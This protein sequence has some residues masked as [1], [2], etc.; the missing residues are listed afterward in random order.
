MT[1]NNTND[2]KVFKN[3]A[4]ITIPR[5]LKDFLG[6]RFILIDK[7][8]GKGKKPKQ[9][10]WTT[11]KNYNFNEPIL[12]GHIRGG[13][14]YG[15]AT[16]FGWLQCFDADQC[17]RLEELGILQKLPRT[18][19][20]KTGRQSS[21]GRHYWY[22]IEGMQ[23]RLIFHDKELK[24]PEKED[25]FL[26][27][28]SVQSKGNYAIG[29]NCIHYSGNR[30]EIIDDS[31]IATL[32]YDDLLEILKPT[33]LKKKDDRPKDIRYERNGCNQHSHQEV[34]IER[35]GWPKGNVENANGG[36]EFIGTHPFHDSKFGRN[37][38]INPSKGVWHCFRHDSGGGWV[39][40]L[41][42]KEGIISC[43]QAGKGCL[44]KKQYREVFQKAEEMGLIEEK[45]I[46]APIKEVLMNRKELVAIPRRAPEGEMVV[47]R[48][49]PR[50][51]KSHS[52]CQWLA[53]AGS[54]NYIT[55]NHAIV[56]HEIKIAKELRM[57]GVV[58]IIGMNQPGACVHSGERKCGECALKHGKDN[59]FELISAAIKL[60]KEKEVLT[61][62]DIPKNYCPYYILKIA[63]KHANYCFTVV[64]NINNIIPRKLTIIDEEPT[65]NHFYATSLEVATIK[66]RAGESASKNFL[67]KSAQIQKELDQILN[68]RKKPALKEYAQKIQDISKIIDNGI[69]EGLSVGDIADEIEDSLIQFAPKHREVRDEGEHEEG[70]DLGI[71]TCVRCIGNLYKENPINV[72]SKPGGYQS[73]Y[74]LGDER[75]PAFAMDWLQKTEKIIIIGATKAELFANEFGGREIIIPDFIY[76]DRFTLIG[77]EK[78]KIGDNRGARNAQKKKVMDIAKA[79]WR[80]SESNSRTPFLM[81]T[82]SK[83]EQEIAA[84]MLNGAAT[85]RSERENGMEW[86][87][88]SGKPVVIF[89]NSIISRGLDVD[90]FNLM[91]V[92]GCNFA[93]PFWSVADEGIAAAIISDE[94]TNS[95]LRISSTLRSD[96]KTMKLVIMQK[97][98]LK[99]VKYLS[100]IR[101]LSEEAD[102]VAK[103]IRKLGVGGKIEKDG[104]KG[105]KVTSSG[106]KNAEGKEKIIE[107][108]SESADIVDDEELES[109]MAR[110]VGFMRE[111]KMRR[112]TSSNSSAIR[113]GISK[114]VDT[115][116]VTSAMQKLYALGILK[117]ESHGREKKW[118]LNK[119]KR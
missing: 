109:V 57:R 105:V 45:I 71:E 53:D 88:S 39:E 14:N 19:T 44:T 111:Q 85:V 24:N 33:R 76:D 82:G 43:E 86:E 113:R 5:Q 2:V 108:I 22:K 60:L 4:K 40:L 115:N 35:I 12:V 58:W 31:E 52:A 34:D 29:P 116:I 27:L 68:H 41:A 49:P 118:S 10:K 74:I 62:R 1:S 17:G 100:N 46:D 110:I 66:T 81:L 78:K 21:E 61:A 117:M 36:T 7:L 65:L 26:E 98:D 90:Q 73:I 20:V 51:G 119:D 67:A 80:N 25:E 87:M 8:V 106:I 93:Q 83:R 56:E 91:F 13:G 18:F 15:I 47:I 101:V 69:D 30:Y 64:N 107:L 6:S 96:E 84:S 103:I 3:G 94:T 59:H 75:K 89:Q 95:V 102:N 63:E 28:G 50:T 99:K 92:Y 11:E 32:K 72:I 77:V 16:G 23:K 54:G 42:V 70:E 55:H 38:S 114:R 9:R 104:R 97:D 37:F 79:V 48:A 112:V